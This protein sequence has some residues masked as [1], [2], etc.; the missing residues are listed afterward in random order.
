MA[1]FVLNGNFYFQFS[2]FFSLKKNMEKKIATRKQTFFLRVALL[3]DP[4]WQIVL[5]KRI[6]IN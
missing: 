3:H 2:I 5:N 6:H 1:I 4:F